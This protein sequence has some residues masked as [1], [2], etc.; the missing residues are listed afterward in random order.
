MTFKKWRTTAEGRQAAYV[1]FVEEMKGIEGM[2]DDQIIER[3]NHYNSY[4]TV[5][6]EDTTREKLIVWLAMVAAKRIV[7]A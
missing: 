5:R 3:L 4:A 6:G 2:T 1:R 7:D